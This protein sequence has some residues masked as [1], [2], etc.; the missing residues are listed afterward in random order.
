MCP[1]PWFDFQLFEESF[2]GYGNFT[3]N[4]ILQHFESLDADVT[5]V[6][7]NKSLKHMYIHLQ[8]KA[9]S[10]NYQIFC[11]SQNFVTYLPSTSRQIIRCIS[12]SDLI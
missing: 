4:I 8:Q 12:E 2:A 9:D 5:C 10:S 6:V 7:I 3:I 1:L 11:N